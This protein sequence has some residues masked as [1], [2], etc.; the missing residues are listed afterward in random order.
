MLFYNYFD[1]EFGF[2]KMNKWKFVTI[3]NN[4]HYYKSEC[5]L[6]A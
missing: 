2:F 6:L 3:S 1:N 5:N 4:K